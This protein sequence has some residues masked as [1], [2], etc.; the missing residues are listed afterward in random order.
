MT[1][2]YMF[3]EDFA[4]GAKPTITV[5]EADRRR[6]DAEAAGASQ[7]LRRRP[8]AGARRSRASAS[9]RALSVI[10][11][12]L[13]RLDSA[14]DGIEARL[15]TEAVEVAVAVAGKL[16]PELI[17][18]EPFAEI[19]ALANECFRQLVTTPHI[20]VRVGADIYDDRQGQARRDRAT[21]GFEG[22]LVVL[23]DARDGAGDCRIE[24]ADG[25]V[26]RDQAATLCRDR[27]RGRPLRR[28][29]HHG[30]EQ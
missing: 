10:A 14:L 26:N 21:R 20:V 6:E 1:A 23:A 7:G 5:V 13:S 4:T 2:K 19:S 8:G 30:A 29:A 15:E 25:G 18:R 24:W 22:R 12:G 3:D 9:P 16:A 11:D 27:R 17:A 28:G